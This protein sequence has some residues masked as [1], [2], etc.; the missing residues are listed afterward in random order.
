MS[1]IESI[2]L[3][4]RLPKESY[5]Q[6]QALAATA[7]ISVNRFLV[8]ALEEFL[9]QRTREEIDARFTEMAT[10]QAYQREA[11]ALCREF[12]YADYESGLA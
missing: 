8:D 4:V 11:L 7:T 1:K 12:E 2:T 5:R 3:T 9:K 6:A 10:D